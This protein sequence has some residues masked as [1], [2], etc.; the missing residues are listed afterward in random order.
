MAFR[1]DINITLTHGLINISA[2]VSINGA[3]EAEQ[4]LTSVCVGTPLGVPDHAPTPLKQHMNCKHCGPISYADIKKAKVSGDQY[5]V[6]DKEEV[7]AAHEQV[8]GTSKKLLGLT[9][10]DAEEVF[11]ATL[12]GKSLYYVEPQG[13]GQL[14]GYG[15][16]YDVVSRHPE[17]AFLTEFTPTSRAGLYQ[18][19]AFNGA[20]VLQ[21]LYWPEDVKAAPVTQAI[22]P[23]TGLQG[24][25]DGLLEVMAQPFAPE[26][27]RNDYASA[28][29]ALLAS[30][31]A[32]IGEVTESSGPRTKTAATTVG[33]VD[34]SAQLA[35]LL[36][37]PA[38]KPA[39]KPRA[40]K[41]S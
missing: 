2:T 3:T 23:D 40:R 27:Y 22:V 36:G 10:H 1:K 7:A 32:V 9:V 31:E 6:V 30:K 20:L 19:R 24:Q 28:L 12:P 34:L 21:S 14:A 37:V 39:R 8:V 29:T 17:R 4:S 15:L 26:H 35:A 41:A 5:T 33:A 16:L 13:A 38:A 11:M 18:L 25:L